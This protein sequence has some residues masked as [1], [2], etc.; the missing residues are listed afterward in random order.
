M[1]GRSAN[2]LR[3]LTLMPQNRA[4]APFD[5]AE[6]VKI[7]VKAGDSVKLLLLLLGHRERINEVHR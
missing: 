3:L 1:V 5:L 6:V 2:T 4:R 7:V